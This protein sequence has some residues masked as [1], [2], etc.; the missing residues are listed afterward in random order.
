MAHCG[1]GVAAVLS[2]ALSANV[3]HAQTLPR[4]VPLSEVQVQLQTGGG[5]GC[6]IGGC[7]D[8]RITIRGDGLVTLRK[9]FLSPPRRETTTHPVSR[10]DIVKLVN[11]FL[12]AGFVDLPANYRSPSRGA[13]LSGDSL[14]FGGWMDTGGYSEITLTLGTFSKTVRLY[15]S[16]PSQLSDVPAA[17]TELRNRIWTMGGGPESWIA[18]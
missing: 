6:A 11:G 4:S 17:L 3:L 12:S 18:K 10:E 14:V 8:Y 1:V 16:M 5:D 13:W 7:V 2:L 9:D 15:G